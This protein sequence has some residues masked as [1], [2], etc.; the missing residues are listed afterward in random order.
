MVGLFGV[1]GG[2]ESLVITCEQGVNKKTR[3]GFSWAV[4]I[5]HGWSFVKIACSFGFFIFKMIS[6]C[7]YLPFV[8][9]SNVFMFVGSWNQTC[10]WKQKG[11]PNVTRFSLSLSFFASSLRLH[12]STGSVIILKHINP[13]HPPPP[14]PDFFFS[15]SFSSVLVH[16]R[17]T[18]MHQQNPAKQPLCSVIEAVWFN[19]FKL[20]EGFAW[21]VCLSLISTVPLFVF[22][23]FLF[24]SFSLSLW[25]D[26]CERGECW[27]Y[28]CFLSFSPSVWFDIG[29]VMRCVCV[30]V[31]GGGG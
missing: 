16:Y 3:T 1:G 18:C 30:C 24:S 21:S 19:D 29:Q 28:F 27:L 13:Q 31:W 14:P 10:P 12:A 26:I 17:L 15:L 2:E 9:F 4:A 22:L 7:Q 23:V 11:P 6:S 20:P 8:W 5:S 25:F